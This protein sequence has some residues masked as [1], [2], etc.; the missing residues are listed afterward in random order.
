MVKDD[1]VG[2][3]QLSVSNELRLVMG[4][5]RAAH[6]LTRHWIENYGMDLE[7]V[8]EAIA[9]LLVILVERLRLLDRVGRGTLDPRLA[10]CAENDADRS[11]RDPNEDDVRLEAWS[12][13]DLVRHHRAEWKRV[14]RRL[15]KDRTNTAADVSTP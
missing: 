9:S 7:D 10:W 4:S 2:A 14:K 5:I 1:R 13:L 12:D 3:K 8:P 11:H 15:R 6:A